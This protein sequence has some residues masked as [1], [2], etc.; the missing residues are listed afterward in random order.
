MVHEPL[1]Q[2]VAALKI[3]ICRCWHQGMENTCIVV[4]LTER[5][6]EHENICYSLIP[7]EPNGY[8]LTCEYLHDLPCTSSIYTLPLV[9]YH[10][11]DREHD[12]IATQSAFKLSRWS[13]KWAWSRKIATKSAF[14]LFDASRKGAWSR[15]IATKSAF[16]LNRQF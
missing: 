1:P 15:K 8:I 10:Q 9:G 7:C 12:K 16:K 6:L 3:F 5:V 2:L 14:K 11:N 13:T 4:L